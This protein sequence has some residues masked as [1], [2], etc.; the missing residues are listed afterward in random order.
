[1][2]FTPPEEVSLDVVTE[3]STLAIR[4]PEEFTF[5]QCSLIDSL[6]LD[7]LL[8]DPPKGFSGRDSSSR[9]ASPRG[10]SP[11]GASPRG[12][13]PRGVSPR[14]TS[15]RGV[16]PRGTSPRGASPR[17]T[18]PRGA[19]PK[20]FTA[21]ESIPK[22]STAEGSIPKESALGESTSKGCIP[23]A[24]TAEGSIPKE[25]ALGESTSKGCIP[26]ASTAEG[27]IPKESAFGESISKGCIPKAS[28]CER[29]ILK[30][31]APK[32]S[33]SKE[34]ILKESAPEETTSE[35]STQQES[36]PEQ[37]IVR[38]T[39]SGLPIIRK[40]I[41]EAHSFPDFFSEDFSQYEDAPRANQRYHQVMLVGNEDDFIPYGL[42]PDELQR[43]GPLRTYDGYPPANEILIRGPTIIG[44]SS[45]GHLGYHVVSSCRKKDSNDVIWVLEKVIDDLF[46][47]PLKPTEILFSV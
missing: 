30:E 20:G 7:T 37:P 17:E 22:P 11:R 39:A 40:T 32:T 16:S 41:Y 36:S 47:P 18:S 21:E 6:P 35:E 19:S 2:S 24:V 14:G 31:S 4:T 29:C 44:I 43:L 25:F 33:T 34:S 12:T 27:S 1:M 28:L 10:T 38:E 15:P 5:D 46:K 8:L 23:K 45:L 9:G 3:E 42:T 26:K 13:S